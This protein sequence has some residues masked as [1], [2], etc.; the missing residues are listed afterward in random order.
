MLTSKGQADTKRLPMMPIRDVV[1][2]G[3]HNGAAKP[4][5]CSSLLLY[6]LAILNNT[7]RGAR[8]FPSSLAD[9]HAA[10]SFFGSLRKTAAG[11]R[12]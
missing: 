11:L 6:A 3:S 12:T 5:V 10:T 1:I 9:P 4:A 7:L 2:G 8:I